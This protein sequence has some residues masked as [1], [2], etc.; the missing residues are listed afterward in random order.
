[1]SWGPM[2]KAAPYHENLLPHGTL[3]V[4]HTFWYLLYS[5]IISILLFAAVSTDEISFDSKL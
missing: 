4:L 1:M 3:T 5:S 2:L